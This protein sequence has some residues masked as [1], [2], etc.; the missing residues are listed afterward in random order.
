MFDSIIE[1]DKNITLFK[2][3]GRLDAYG[4]N[5]IDEKVKSIDENYNSIIL[6]LS[7]VEYLSSAG[8]RSLL[9]LQKECNKKK[10]SVLISGASLDIINVIDMTGMTKIFSF[11]STVEEAKKYFFSN[12][13]SSAGSIEKSINNKK[14]TIN[15]L[16]TQSS[17]IDIWGNFNQQSGKNIES[18]NL[19]QVNLEELEFAAGTGGFGINKHQ[20]LAGTGEFISAKKFCGTVPA[21]NHNISDFIIPEHPSDANMFVLSGFGISGNPSASIEYKGQ[22]AVIDEILS[23]MF[24][25]ANELTGSENSMIGII[26]QAKIDKINSSFYKNISDISINKTTVIDRRPDEEHNLINLK[27]N[28]IKIGDIQK[29]ADNIFS[30]AVA[31][32]DNISYKFGN[33][34]IKSFLDNLTSYKSQNN[35][36]AHTHSVEYS[37]PDNIIEQS[38]DLNSM[39]KNLANLEYLK[40]VSH[41]NSSTTVTSCKIWLFTPGSI[42]PG[43]EKQ[44]KIEVE[45]NYDFREEWEFITRRIYN[46]SSKVVITPLQGGFSSATFR[47][48]SFDKDGR[49]ILPTVM[50]IGSIEL[51]KKEVDAYK[52]CVEKFILNNSTTIMGVANCGKWSG[53]R[54]NF[55]GITGSAGKLTWLENIY[56]DD[57]PEKIIELFDRVFTDILKPWYG[58]PKWEEIH[59]YEEQDP[60]KLFSN[61]LGDAEKE[62]GISPETKT[63]QCPELGIELPNPFNFYKYE[64]PKRKKIAYHWYTGIT[65]GDLNMKNILIDDKENIYVIDFSECKK[66]NITVDFARLEPIVLFEM[67]KIDNQQDLTELLKFIQTVTQTKRF[68]DYIKFNY[69]GSD[70]MVNKAYKTICRMRYYADK[71]TLFETNLIP[72]II[73]LLEW[74]YPVVSYISV[75]MIR[76]KCAVYTAAMLVKQIFDIEKNKKD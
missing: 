29:R 34:T 33:E 14:Y 51:T 1:K 3:S 69:S 50:K 42:R 2:L 45:G 48:N 35:I 21:D 31:A 67:T 23:D 46:D 32:K 38:S 7:K 63:I 65:H 22:P 75:P 4:A 41:L 53:L 19:V 10:G 71:V 49:K 12:I 55:V 74:T 40:N 72:Y 76:K 43:K 47:V 15:N 70:P 66:T 58:Q 39:I 11:Y 13:A 56:K 5:I 62:M 57:N 8:I 25:I 59:P 6:D 20:A 9:K 26:L 54:Y 61:I 36:S 52:L 16:G 18:E 24:I 64:Y 30:I 37:D 28:V 73:A 17:F 68:D 60:G 27:H 44:I